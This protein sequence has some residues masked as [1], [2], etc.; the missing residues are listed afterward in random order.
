MDIGVT[1]QEIFLKY[2][3][4]VVKMVENNGHIENAK[5]NYELLCDIEM[6]LGLACIL[7]C[8]KIMQGLSKFAPKR[9]TIICDFIYALKLAK[10]DLII[11]YCDN[12]K[13]TTLNISFCS[14]NLLRTLMMFYV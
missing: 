10:V 3:L 8:L 14:L 9:D 4:L 1:L 5:A 11:M 12:E 13:S 2:K 7:P 6:L